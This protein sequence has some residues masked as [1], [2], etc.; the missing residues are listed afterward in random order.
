ALE[1]RL[2]AMV[3][4][5]QLIR[6]RAREFCLTRHLDL[7]TGVVLAHRDG[8]GFL[9]PDDGGDDVYLPPR[10]MRALWDGDRVA[11]RVSEGR[12]GKLEGRVV[13]VLQRT[14]TNLVGHFHRERGIDYV[15]EEADTRTEV[16]IGRGDRNGAKP[17]DL[18]NVEIV[19]HPTEHSLA[20]GRVVKVVGRFDDPGIET[21]VAMLAHG[22]PT[23]WPGA[24]AEAARRFPPQ[25]SPAAKRNR[26]DLR[27]VPLVTIDGADAKDFDDAVYCEPHGDGWK[28]LVAIADVSHYVEPDAPL[29]REARVRGTSVYFPDRV[30]PMLP[31]E[32]SNGLCSLNPQVDRLCLACEMIVTRQ[33]AVKRSRFLNGVMRSHARLTYDGAMEL[34]ENPGAR[35]PNAKLRPHLLRLKEVFHAFSRARRRRGA[36]DFDLP[37]TKIELDEQG[38]VARVQAVDRLVTHQIIEECMIAANV[39]AAKRIRKTRVPGLYRVHE[40]PDADRLEELTLFLKTFGFKLPPAGKLTPK[41]LS[42]VVDRVS[43]KPE[44]ELIETVV[45]KSMKRASYHPKNIGHFGLGLPAYAHFTSPIR[46][47]PDLLVHRAIKWVLTNGSAK[48]Y[49]Y[50]LPEMEHLGERCSRAE[51]R[52]D[53]AVWD[54]EE[55]LK[56]IYMS[57]RVGQDFRVVVS[58]VQPFGLFVRVPE[59]QVDGLVHVT[60]LPRDYYHRDPTG[61]KLAGERT[62][63]VYGL[64]DTM[65]VRLVG[66]NVEERKI[67]FVPIERLE[68]GEEREAEPRRAPRGRQRQH[69]RRRS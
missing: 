6:N 48:G 21:E 58:G 62:G 53:E 5:G 67:D 57:E 1:N 52:A 13:E 30:V 10:D 65:Q 34:L 18:V 55:Q 66:A 54:V 49:P 51:R 41:H 16:L 7:K 8:F 59:L 2:K 29:D 26:E 35:G 24:V 12:Q 39:E 14:K 9:R 25:V 42:D 19:Q 28:V 11:V 60:S 38:K 56:C 3:R 31:E 69:G 61:T 37:Q 15:L 40:G 36:I 44:A 27:K 32:L 22:I 43:G 50:T 4:D 47:Y 46:R 20:I 33:G 45:L 68:Q 63:A 23:E 64:T 17:G